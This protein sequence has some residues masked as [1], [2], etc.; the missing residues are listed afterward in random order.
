MITC[1]LLLLSTVQSSSMPFLVWLGGFILVL[2][3]GVAGVAGSAL[4][5]VIII[6]AFAFALGAAAG[7]SAGGGWYRRP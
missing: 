4:L 3:V 2:P 7:A 5:V 1:W 6:L